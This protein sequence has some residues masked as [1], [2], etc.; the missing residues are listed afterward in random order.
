MNKRVVLV[1]FNGESMCFV[2]VLLNALDMNKKGYEVKVVIEG[3]ATK[4]IG[5][6]GNEDHPFSK[7]YIE[8]RE[9]GMIDCVCYA[10]ATKMGSVDAAQAQG[11]PLCREMKGH[12]SLAT[13]MEQGYEVITF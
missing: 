7:P 6:L 10:C 11:L 2:H 13:Y 12:P 5:E 9:K 4:L 3:S 1:A 8:V